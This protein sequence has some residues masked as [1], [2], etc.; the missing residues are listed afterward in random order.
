[1][2][3]WFH[4]AQNS[5]LI[6][7]KLDV[8]IALSPPHRVTDRKRLLARQRLSVLFTQ[9]AVDKSMQCPYRHRSIHGNASSPMSTGVGRDLI[10]GTIAAADPIVLP[11]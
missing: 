9:S 10:R 2:P 7:S 6:Q 1:M 5:K 3:I 11:A 4:P 8:M